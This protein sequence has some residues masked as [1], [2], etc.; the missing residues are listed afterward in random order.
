MKQTLYSE[1]NDHKWNILNATTLK[2]IAV[3]FMFLDHIHQMFVHVGAPIWL[4]MVGRMVFPIFLFTSAESFRYTHSKKNYLQRLLFASWGMTLFTVAL[5]S[6]LPNQQ[7]VLM[8]NTFATFF[9]T[10]LYM[11]FWDIFVDGIQNRNPVQVG[12]AVLYGI[13]PFLGAV[14]LL[15]VAGLS[16]NEAIP[17]PVLRILITVAML[18]PNVI[19]IEGG[20]AMVALGVSFYIF[21]KHR[22]IQIAILLVLS[23]VTYLIGDSIQWM[24]CCAVIPIALYNGERGKGMKHF[25]YLFYPLHIGVL[26]L[27]S[28]MDF[29]Y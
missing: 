11:L 7:V 29:S 26:Y 2:L 13:L 19:A 16:S 18:V 27:I 25:F 3:F 21:R 14:P 4:T 8:N 15:F 5:Q 24:M 10:G 12:K 23:A 17:F 22:V 1:Q 28:T 9:V 6:I 20:V